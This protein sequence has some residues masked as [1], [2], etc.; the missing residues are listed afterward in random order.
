MNHNNVGLMAPLREANRSL[1][2]FSATIND[3]PNK[4]WFVF[5]PFFAWLC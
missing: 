5:L 4:R 2:R 3:L 1:K